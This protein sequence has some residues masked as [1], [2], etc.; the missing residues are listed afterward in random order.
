MGVGGR[1]R[2]RHGTGWALRPH[3]TEIWKQWKQHQEGSSS[4][5]NGRVISSRT[6]SSAKTPLHRAVHTTILTAVHTRYLH[7]KQ[8]SV[9]SLKYPRVHLRRSSKESN[10]LPH[11]LL[12]WDGS[13]TVSYIVKVLVVFL[14]V[15]PKGQ[16][17]VLL[18]SENLEEWVNMETA[19]ARNEPQHVGIIWIMSLCRRFRRQGELFAQ[20][21]SPTLR[22]HSARKA[23]WMG[24][25][26]HCFVETSL[27][28]W[29]K[30]SFCQSTN[31]T[32]HTKAQVTMTHLE[33]RNKQIKCF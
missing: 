26:R 13:R 9:R 33:D 6:H 3:S 28:A 31:L 1:I 16:V 11:W 15:V 21:H 18:I 29:R 23:Q 20:T 17:S 30:Q 24:N 12:P 2:R 7:G 25:S 22:R 4:Q 19:K 5:D 8:W 14:Y 32:G 10:I 27:R